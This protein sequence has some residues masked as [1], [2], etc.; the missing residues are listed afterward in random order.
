MP[1]LINLTPHD[2]HIIGGGGTVTIQAS[3]TVARC[4]TER[5][6]IGWTGES[7]TSIPIYRTIFGT[8][9][10]LPDPQPGT[11][12]IVSSLAAQA[13]RERKD[14]LI[15]DDAVRDDQ[16]RVIGCRALARI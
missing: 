7:E 2:I 15:P 10:G 13:A 14:L 6:L 11:W 8:V 1:K 9:D 5:Q 3:G 16:G 12:Y 4:K